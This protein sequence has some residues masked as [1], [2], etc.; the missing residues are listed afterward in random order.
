MATVTKGKTFI[1]GELVTPAA[2]H[3]LVDSATV[4]AI[5]NADIASNAAIADTKLATISTAGKVLPA[6]VQGTAVITTDSRLSDART[7][8]AHNHDDRYYTETEIDT[9]LSGLPVAGHTHSAADITSGTLANA[10]TTATSA[11]TAST[12]VARDASSNFSAGR[13][14]SSQ[15]IP[16]GGSL[17]FADT[18]GTDFELRGNSTD[19]KLFLRAS[20]VDILEIDS[21]SGFPVWKF[22]LF[23]SSKV[24]L[25]KDNPA[26]ALDVNGTITAT[27]FAGNNVVPVGAVMPFAMSTAPSGWLAA[28]GSEYS[29]TGTYAA[30]FAV[31]GATHGETNG[32]GG[33]GTSHFRVPDLRGLFVRGSGSQTFGGLTYSSTFASKNQDTFKSHSHP[34]GGSLSVNPVVA[35]NAPEA[36]NT[37]TSGSAG[38][39]TSVTATTSSAGVNGT[40]NLAGGGE[41]APAN[42]ALLYCI[43][44]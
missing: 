9:R 30:L 33:A 17:I 19:D 11:N 36:G 16:K 13:V 6:A 44:F 7:P 5:V 26:T 20:G 41:T 39:V 31:I 32:S 34:F 38:R 24:G 23:G 28:D 1:N 18:F 3:Q 43:K 40:T 4:T 35:I 2:L 22:K 29:K 15:T 14:N 27:A 42:I 37:A 12:I 21:T 8:T 10:R 25:F